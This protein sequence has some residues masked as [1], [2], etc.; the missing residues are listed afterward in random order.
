MTAVFNNDH[1]RTLLDPIGPGAYRSSSDIF[2]PGTA[3]ADCEDDGPDIVSLV[4]DV[5]APSKNA[6][7][8][9]GTPVNATR[10]ITGPKAMCGA[11]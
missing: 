11:L 6:I 2:S 4:G 10:L 3:A 7:S 9:I 8:K 1:Q 5:Q